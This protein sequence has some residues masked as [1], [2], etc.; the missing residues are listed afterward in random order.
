M[1]N[2]IMLLL[3]TFSFLTCKKDQSDLCE[4]VICRN[5]GTCV[6]GGCNCPENYTGPDCT[7]QK[8]PISILMKT[9]TVTQVPQTDG[10]AGWDLTSGPDI[11]VVITDSNGN[12]MVNTRNAFKQNS[13]SGTFQI[14]WRIENPLGSYHF[15]VYDYDDNLSADDYI[16]GVEGLIYNSTNGFPS[17]KSLTCGNCVVSFS[18]PL[19]YFF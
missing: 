19:E 14:N 5:G 7:Q 18:A 3:I 16:G 1:K 13:F 17:S 11:F 2:L 10:G 9:I 15:R 8:T 6:N 4:G 12:E